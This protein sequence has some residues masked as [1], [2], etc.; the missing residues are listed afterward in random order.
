MLHSASLLDLIPLYLAKRSF[1]PVSFIWKP[2][3]DFFIRYQTTRAMMAARKMLSVRLE[4]RTMRENM[5]AGSMA[6]VPAETPFS[7]V[8][9]GPLVR[10]EQK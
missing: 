4:R 3:V 2:V 6:S 5:K 1:S 9:R 10:K 8:F 7:A